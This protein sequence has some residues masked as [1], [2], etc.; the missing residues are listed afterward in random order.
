MGSVCTTA[1]AG[2]PGAGAEPPSGARRRSQS[3]PNPRTSLGSP[4]KA[5]GPPATADTAARNNPGRPGAIARRA[6]ATAAPAGARTLQSFV[7]DTLLAWLADKAATGATSA[8]FCPAKEHLSGA[9]AFVDIRHVSI[10]RHTIAHC[11][12]CIPP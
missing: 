11:R 2:G 6:Q 1:C 8:T 5:G 3:A 9:V 10:F 12:A 7:P 4:G